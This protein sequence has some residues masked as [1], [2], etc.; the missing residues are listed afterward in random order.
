M[1]WIYRLIHLY[2]GFLIGFVIIRTWYSGLISVNTNGLHRR[3]HLYRLVWLDKFF[4]FKQNLTAKIIFETAKL[5]ALFLFHL[6]IHL[7]TLLPSCWIKN[8]IFYNIHL[9]AAWL[10]YII[11]SFNESLGGC[12]SVVRTKIV[13]GPTVGST[14]DLSSRK[15]TF[16]HICHRFILRSHLTT[17]IVFSLVCVIDL[18]PAIYSFLECGRHDRNS[19]PSHLRLEFYVTTLTHLSRWANFSFNAGCFQTWRT[20][21]NKTSR[22][23][24]PPNL[25]CDFDLLARFSSFDNFRLLNEIKHQI[26]RLLLFIARANQWWF[27]FFTARRVG[28]TNLAS[29]INI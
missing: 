24:L 20:T 10:S 12:S 2:I 22:R 9:I 5:C 4:I 27:V 17:I 18:F 3:I 13:F 29:A 16:W 6:N 25:L 11:H 28:S 8:C 23:I 14:K 15:G 26:W 7:L 1:K 19:F 21:A